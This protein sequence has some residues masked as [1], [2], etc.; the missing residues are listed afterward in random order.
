MIST[1]RII[2][3]VSIRNLSKFYEI[4]ESNEACVIVLQAV[5]FNLNGWVTFVWIP[6]ILQLI[7]WS[8]IG[9]CLFEIPGPN[10]LIRNREPKRFSDIL[11]GTVCGCLVEQVSRTE[12]RP[13]CL[14]V[15]TWLD[16]KESLPCPGHIDCQIIESPIPAV[17]LMALPRLPRHP[18]DV[19]DHMA[20][21]PV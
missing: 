9:P 21:S 3:H 17:V 14:F 15:S 18:G 5:A 6:S 10:W 16:S 7:S 19:I 12:E 20:Y 1:G 11:W 4:A 13:G 8:L 2:E